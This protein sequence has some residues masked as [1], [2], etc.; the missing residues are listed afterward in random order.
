MEYF[1]IR[2][3]GGGGVKEF[4]SMGLTERS[5]TWRLPW[6]LSISSKYVVSI[7]DHCNCWSFV[8]TTGVEVRGGP[9]I[10]RSSV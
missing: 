3:R 9:S 8:I 6:L 4:D 7:L 1:I 5:L 10:A 2:G